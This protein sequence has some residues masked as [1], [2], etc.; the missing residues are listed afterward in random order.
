MRL[1]IDVYGTS[2]PRIF[3]SSPTS[4]EELEVLPAHGTET[5]SDQRS[6]YFITLPEPGYVVGFELKPSESPG[7]I[8]VRLTETP[9]WL[10]S[11]PPSRDRSAS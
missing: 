5:S 4:L 6:R 8:R 1:A 11:Q 3:I 10:S 9:R 2:R 7:F